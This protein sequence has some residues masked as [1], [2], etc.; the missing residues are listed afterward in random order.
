MAEA[1]RIATSLSQ[2]KKRGRDDPYDWDD[3]TS[4]ELQVRAKRAKKA[5]SQS[6][7]KSQAAPVSLSFKPISIYIHIYSYCMFL[8]NP[9]R[10]IFTDYWSVF[11]NFRFMHDLLTINLSIIFSN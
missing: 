1:E 6:Q 4:A 3:D 10:T 7:S 9:T 5:S 8:F 2:P 11:G